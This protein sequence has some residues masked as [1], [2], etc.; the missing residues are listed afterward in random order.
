MIY[1]HTHFCLIDRAF[2][3]PF[4]PRRACAR[5][6]VVVLCVSLSVCLCVCVSVTALAASVSIYIRKQRYTQ[7]SRRLFLDLDSWIFE[8]TFRSKV[9]PWKSQYANELELTASRLCT[10]LGPTKR[11]SYILEWQLVGGML[12]QTLATAASGQRQAMLD[13]PPMVGQS[14]TACV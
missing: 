14:K 1:S 2:R 12:L 11:S 6:T 3:Q 4:N 8:K 9:R 5:V 13:E 7:V 10:L